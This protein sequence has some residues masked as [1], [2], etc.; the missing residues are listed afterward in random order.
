MRVLWGEIYRRVYEN[1]SIDLLDTLDLIFYEGFNAFFPVWGLG[2]CV[3]LDSPIYEIRK[4]IGLSQMQISIVL[5]CSQSH[6]SAVECGFSFFTAGMVEA[7]RR[8]HVDLA[9]VER[10]Q[11]EF[12]EYRRR[13][14][15]GKFRIS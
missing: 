13:E 14:L 8:M 4:K 11:R 15:E 12:I 10:R 5:G 1:R 6:I 9:E 3:V 2:R 7:L